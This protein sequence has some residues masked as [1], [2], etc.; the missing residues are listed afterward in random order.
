M[1]RW[2]PK[3]SKVCSPTL[4]LLQP[5]AFLSVA[6]VCPY[7][8]LSGHPFDYRDTIQVPGPSEV[9]KA[10]LSREPFLLPG[11]GPLHPFLGMGV[12]Y[13]PPKTVN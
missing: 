6:E 5:Q 7:E 9:S 3:F 13:S 1:F 8:S 11:R 12:L 4:A 2:P 10:I